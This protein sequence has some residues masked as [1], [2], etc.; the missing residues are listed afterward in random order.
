MK[1]CEPLGIQVV[2]I[3][4]WWISGSSQTS[5]IQ[6]L[7][8]GLVLKTRKQWSFVGRL[9]EEQNFRSLAGNLAADP[10]MA[11][12]IDFRTTTHPWFCQDPMICISLSL[13]WVLFIC[14]CSLLTM[15][16][17]YVFIPS[18]CTHTRSTHHPVSNAECANALW[19]LGL[20]QLSKAITNEA[21]V[22][23]VLEPLNLDTACG[24]TS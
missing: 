11:I 19:P 4:L 21:V 18:G 10:E 16:T 23:V 1:R 22:L 9:L 12:I 15:A 5:I 17:Q 14:H 20:P 3:R 2:Y 7:I 8:Q 6:C 13:P 24:L